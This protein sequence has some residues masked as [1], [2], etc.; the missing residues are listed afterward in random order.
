MYRLWLADNYN[1]AASASERLPPDVHSRDEKG[2]TPL[3]HASM[4]G[5]IEI[6]QFL[7]GNRAEIDA[8]DED[9][10]TPLHL[11]CLK[12]RLDIA[13]L[14]IKNGAKIH[15]SREHGWAPIHAA[16]TGGKATTVE[17][18][19]RNGADVRARNKEGVTPLHLAFARGKVEVLELLLRGGADVRAR[20]EDGT[21]PIAMRNP[22]VKLEA[23][24]LLYSYGADIHA[25]DE[26][27]QSLLHST[28]HQGSLRMAEFLLRNGAD[29]HAADHKG[30]TPLHVACNVSS[31]DVVEFLL[32]N[33]ADIEA[34]DLKRRTPFYTVCLSKNLKAAAV[35]V[36]NGADLNAADGKGET[37]LHVACDANNLDVVEFLLKNGADI[38]ALDSRSFTALHRVAYRREQRTLELFL[39]Y[40]AD[41]NGL[42]PNG[43]FTLLQSACICGSPEQTEFL[44][45]NGADINAPISSFDGETL[46]EWA[47]KKGRTQ[48]IALLLAWGARLPKAITIG[49][50]YTSSYETSSD[51][52]EGI[53]VDQLLAEF[54]EVS[55]LQ[56]AC[57]HNFASAAMH[58]L[59]NGASL[60]DP[61]T[62]VFLL[63]KN[64]LPVTIREIIIQAHLD[65]VRLMLG[66]EVHGLR[67]SEEQLAQ[68]RREFSLY[69]GLDPEHFTAEMLIERRDTLIPLL[70]GRQTLLHVAALRNDPGAVERLIGVGVAVDAENSY[71]YTASD[72]ADQHADGRC[73]EL[74]LQAGGQVTYPARADLGGIGS[75]LTAKILR[76]LTTTNGAPDIL[77]LRGI[78]LT[79]KHFSP[80]PAIAMRDIRIDQRSHANGAGPA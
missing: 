68:D 33:G 62:V 41:I 43:Y 47:C 63:E 13:D 49:S 80:F 67:A 7:L 10:L 70:E 74:L 46:I 5:E 9:E 2:R 35:L 56:F 29:I 30:R 44:I 45:R 75:D 32:R 50:D 3:H 65:L 26:M 38:H 59:R 36:R 18:L 14:L 58:H 12:G 61:D 21:E 71:G 1:R 54:R 73:R 8:L 37:P 60:P 72:Y 11:A 48:R 64:L 69:F 52:E 22:D 6:V 79:A 16:S 55:L 57:R 77:S 31:L 42:D 25:T 51:E 40:G 66:G 27:G 76:M 78:L 23:I 19:M 17:L 34:R 39:R 20:D 15:A 28:C 53:G 24:E 4:N